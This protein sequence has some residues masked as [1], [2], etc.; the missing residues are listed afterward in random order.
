MP[1]IPPTRRLWRCR[2]CG[3]R[4]P[5]PKLTF[6]ESREPKN[7]VF[8][9]TFAY[10]ALNK[11]ELMGPFNAYE[12][13]VFTLLAF[14]CRT[15]SDGAT[16]FQKSL[17]NLIQ[18][19][20]VKFNGETSSDDSQERDIM[21][22]DL[23]RESNAEVFASISRNEP[24]WIILAGSMPTT[25]EAIMQIKKK[26]ETERLADGLADSLYVLGIY[27]LHQEAWDAVKEKVCLT[28]K[29]ETSHDFDGHV[30]EEDEVACVHFEDDATLFWQIQQQG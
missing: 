13:M 27:P 3:D 10:P 21:A 22:L 6:F 23:H 24:I 16:S 14:F 30:N 28:Y 26:L 11:W 8:Y 2:T 20:N 17:K 15:F 29:A 25:T 7:T 1:T 12:P 9:V 4:H 18:R 19:G 5:L